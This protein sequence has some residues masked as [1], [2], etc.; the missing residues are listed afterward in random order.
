MNPIIGFELP[1]FQRLADSRR[2]LIAG[3]GGGFD[4]FNGLPL[5]FL[6]RESG[7]EVYLANLSFASLD[8]T[9]G[10]WLTPSCVEITA[11][12]EAY[13][14]YFPEKM[15]CNWFRKQGEEVSIYASPRTGVQPLRETYGKLVEELNLDTIIL[16]DGGTD[17]LMRGDEAGL[18]T[19]AEDM[20]SIAAAHQV[21]VPSKFLVCLGFG[22]DWYHGICHNQ[23]F[24][25]VADFTRDG[26]FLGSVSLLKSMP[27]VARYIDA[28]TVVRQSMSED[29]A[30]IVCSSIV[31]A[32]DGRFG[33]YH[34]TRL[35]RGDSLWI[36]PLMTFY[37]CFD[38][39]KVAERVYYL[40]N[41]INTETYDEVTHAI[42]SFRKTLGGHRRW[43]QIPI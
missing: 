38:L 42:E 9:V 37:W 18:G 2:I 12:L 17:S 5:Y 1:F 40:E 22:V 39:E 8:P 30:S 23:V 36:N 6:L 15:L 21:D 7:R 3:S 4:V 34:S 28:C 20:A 11:D 43:Q 26:G 10:K 25:A 41:I 29:H 31:S 13:L 24:E 33:A 32:L 27:A 19:P 14:N 35:T 16:V